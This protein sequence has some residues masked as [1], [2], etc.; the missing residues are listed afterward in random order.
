[1]KVEDRVK[2]LVEEKIADRPDLF[3]VNVSMQKNGRLTILVDGDE[4][5]T[6]Q[7]CAGISR[8]VGYHLEEENLIE[9][10][11]KLEV[12]SP[13][14]DSPLVMERQYIKNIGRHIAVKTE[15]GDRT[16]GKLAEATATQITID[17]T[18]K[19]KGKKAYS[20]PVSIAIKEIAEIKVII[21]FNK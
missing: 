7:D 10:A 16:E 1:M 14:I 17:V 18:V 12:S 13:G 3:L 21:S 8:H 6:I 5:I 2:E 4:G 20:K 9:N 19:E 11:Y 15:D